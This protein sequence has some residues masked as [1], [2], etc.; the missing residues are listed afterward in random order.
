MLV[1]KPKHAA[2]VSEPY[3]AKVNLSQIYP[4]PA[5][6]P[7]HLFIMDPWLCMKV[8]G[9]WPLTSWGHRGLTRDLVTPTLTSAGRKK[10]EE[11]ESGASSAGWMKGGEQLEDQIQWCAI[12]F[13]ARQEAGSA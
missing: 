5:Q 9:W 7:P 4:Q 8:S 11:K 6:L 3:P 12:M 2:L 10:E 1:L 13:K